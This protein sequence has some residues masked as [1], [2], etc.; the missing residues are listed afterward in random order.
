MSALYDP[1]SGFGITTAFLTNYVTGNIYLTM[2]VYVI[3]LV[4]YLISIGLDREWIAILLSVVL[5][6]LASYLGD[7]FS[8]F[9]IIILFFAA[10]VTKRLV[11]N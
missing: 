5:L 10:I 6:A 2:L 9:A 7:W 4:A 1:T 8:F 3:L 11:G